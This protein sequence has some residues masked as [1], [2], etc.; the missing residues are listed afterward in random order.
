MQIEIDFRNRDPA[1]PPFIRRKASLGEAIHESDDQTIGLFAT[2]Q[3]NPLYKIARKVT[4]IKE[5]TKYQKTV[6]QNG[7]NQREAIRKYV[8]QRKS[9]ERKSSV[10]ANSDVL[11]LFLEDPDTFSEDFIVDELRDFFGAAMMTTQYASQTLIS[12]LIQS[13]ESLTRL[14]EEF[15]TITKEESASGAS[16][17]ETLRKTVLL[18]TVGKLDYLSWVVLETLRIQSPATATTFFEF[19]QDTKVCGVDCRKGDEF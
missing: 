17:L 3:F 15:K 11:S 19:T 14:R 5:F 9:G 16:L 6:A 1:G 12:H 10:A 7:A 8:R 4:G 13:K 18:E 2:K